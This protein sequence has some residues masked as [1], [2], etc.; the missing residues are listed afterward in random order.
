MRLNHYSGSRRGEEGGGRWGGG[1]VYETSVDGGVEWRSR[2][3]PSSSG[4]K[5]SS[6]NRRRSSYGGYTST[7]GGRGGSDDDRDADKRQ[8]VESTAWRDAAWCGGN[9]DAT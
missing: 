3:Y 2:A 1:G 6:D 8:W 4:D 7:Y 9:I 5:R